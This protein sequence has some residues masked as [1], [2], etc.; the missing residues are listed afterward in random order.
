MS[1]TANNFDKI[2]FVE[3][4]GRGIGLILSKEPATEFKEVGRQFIVTFKRK[5]ILSGTRDKTGD[6]T[7]DKII[8][9]IKENFR[10]TAR[11]LAGR[12]G[13]SVK[14]VEWNIK[15]LKA[16]RILKRAGGKK[17]GY[18]EVKGLK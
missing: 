13:L 9:L 12:T 6:K 7:R 18:W 2:N 3:K 14:G 1:C 16:D 10:I 17:G 15:K 11:E 4:W 5:V 8:Q